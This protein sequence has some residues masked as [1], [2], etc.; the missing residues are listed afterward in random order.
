MQTIRTPNEQIISPLNSKSATFVLQALYK[1]MY[2]A[3]F[4]FIVN[5]VN[6]E[7]SH[8]KDYFVTLAH[9]FKI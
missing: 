4:D 8:G 7:L 3:I 5:R 1:G 9:F 6:R 2:K